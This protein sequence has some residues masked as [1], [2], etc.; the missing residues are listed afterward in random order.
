MREVTVVRP[1]GDAIR[2][3]VF[4]A[5]ERAGLSIR[6][7]NIIP[8]GL[9]DDEV[10]GA[11]RGRQPEVF[12][13]PVHVHHDARGA[14]VNGIDVVARIG[15]DLPALIG[16]PILMPVSTVGLAGARLR[17]SARAVSPLPAA[18]RESVLLLEEPR[19]DDPQLIAEIA[20]HVRPR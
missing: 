6:E 3:P 11:L 4:A 1:Y 18:L 10:I 15:R 7:E 5:L 9:S 13:I 14:S 19:L 2:K 12:L 16:V 17:L 8:K 20:A